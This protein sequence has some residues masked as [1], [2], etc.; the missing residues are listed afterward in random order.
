[1]KRQLIE[2]P[3]SVVVIVLLLVYLFWGFFEELSRSDVIDLFEDH[4]V[5]GFVSVYRVLSWNRR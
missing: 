2:L 5:T 4:V 3:F 1:M